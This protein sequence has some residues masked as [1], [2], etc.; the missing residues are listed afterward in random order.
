MYAVHS[1]LYHASRAYSP[2]YAKFMA[3]QNGMIREANSSQIAK[4]QEREI[5]EG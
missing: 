1:G 5:V 4:M 2:L 3:P